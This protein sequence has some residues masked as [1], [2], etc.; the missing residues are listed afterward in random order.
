MAGY[1]IAD[2]E[3]TNQELFAEFAAGILRLVE[4]RNGKYLVRGGTTEVVDGDRT[5]HR[6]VVIQFE[7][8]EKVRDFVNS[9]EYRELAELRSRS[10][11]S[12]T[13]IVEGV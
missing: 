2:V 12:T 6:V 11:T 5:P 10:S 9:A 13:I 8:Y 1:L 4:E 7:S 3:V